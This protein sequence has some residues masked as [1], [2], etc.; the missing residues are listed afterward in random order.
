MKGIIIYYSNTGNTLLACRYMKERLVAVE[1]DFCNVL[2]QKKI[3]LDSY[4]IVGFAT[5]TDAWNVPALFM[6]FI[7]DLK[8]QQQ[9]PA[10]LFNTYGFLSGKTLRVMNKYVT[11]KGFSV[12]CGHSLHTPENFPP[13]IS[14]GLGCAHHPGKK[15]MQKFDDFIQILSG[16]IDDLS[17]HKEVIPQKIKIGIVNTLLPPFPQ[18]MVHPMMGEKKVDEAL[19]IEC[20]V[21]KNNCP[22]DAITLEPKPVFHDNVCQY[23]WACYNKCPKKAIYTTQYRGKYHYPR[24]NDEVKEKLK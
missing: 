2:K 19:C 12:I 7:K 13:M 1:F 4:D 21:C 17:Q 24:P 14:M 11:E 3:S 6:N 16:Y 20:G 15:D 10:F 22:G 18:S 5:Y 8:S 23:C 9:K